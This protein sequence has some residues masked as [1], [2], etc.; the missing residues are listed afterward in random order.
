MDIGGPQGRR[1]IPLNKLYIGFA[2]QDVPITETLGDGKSTSVTAG[3]DRHRSACEEHPRRRSA[4]D[5]DSASASRIEY[6]VAG[7]AVVLKREDNKLTDPAL[8]S[9]A[10]ISRPVL[11]DGTQALCGGPLDERVFKGLDALARPDHADED[12]VHARPLPPACRRCVGAAAAGTAVRELIVER[13]MALSKDFSE[14]R[15]YNAVT[16]FVDANVERG[17]GS[18]SLSSIRTVAHLRSFAGSQVSA[19][20]MPSA[21]WA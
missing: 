4:Y 14:R 12:D 9:P 2:R 15:P 5:T 18:K 7:V 3:R 10:P 17:L 1:T 13:G 16:D 6:P 19:P 11:L 21:T 20:P 8:R